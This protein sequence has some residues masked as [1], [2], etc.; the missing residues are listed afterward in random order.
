[1]YPMGNYGNCSFWGQ[2]GLGSCV[3]SNVFVCVYLSV[4]ALLFHGK[5]DL[6]IRVCVFI[7]IS[8]FVLDVR[9]WEFC[10]TTVIYKMVWFGFVKMVSDA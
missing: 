1:M 8:L 7:Y 2:Y 4:F 6:F 9:K 10:K 5:C 3:N